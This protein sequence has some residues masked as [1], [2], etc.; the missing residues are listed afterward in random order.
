MRCLTF[1]RQNTAD[2][3]Y[4][5][6]D[7]YL[8]LPEI[9]YTL[10]S[11]LSESSKSG[12][13]LLPS[14]EMLSSQLRTIS[15]S[16][17]IH[18]SFAWLGYGAIIHRWQ[19]VEFLGLLEQLNVTQDDI[20]MADNYFTILGN[21]FPEI[22][23]DQGIELGGGQAFTVGNEGEERN[24]RHI[25]RFPFFHVQAQRIDSGELDEGVTSSRLYC[26]PRSSAPCSRV[27]VCAI[28]GPKYGSSCCLSHAVRWCSLSF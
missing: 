7:D 19:A 6:D 13:H 16:S 22:W 12:I 14:H 28:L 27:A 17:G 5:Q 11:R 24:R 20:K 8:I 1:L 10:R 23:F 21:V 3:V 2:D 18:T 15:T 25:V 9:I 4:F 26:Q